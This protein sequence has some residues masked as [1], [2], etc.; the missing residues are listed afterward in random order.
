[1]YGVGTLLQ[2]LARN[3][4]AGLLPLNIPSK[5]PSFPLRGHMISYRSLSDS[6]DTWNAARMSTYVRELAWFGC[7][8]IEMVAPDGLVTPHFQVSQAEMLVILS[9][10]T[11][12]FDLL[13]SIWV[14]Q[15]ANASDPTWAQFVETLTYLDAVFIPAGDP[16]HFSS[17]ELFQFMEEKSRMIHLYHPHCQIW[18]STQGLTKTETASFYKLLRQQQWSWLSGLVY[19]P[20]TRDSYST[21]VAQ[22][23]SMPLPL[24]IRIY[25]DLGH[26]LKSMFPMA[27]VWDP[28]FA[29]VEAREMV[30]PRP[31]HMLAA[32]A[33]LLPN[34]VGFGAYS[35]G[36]IDDVNK[37]V[38]SCA[39]MESPAQCNLSDLLL[40]YARI[41][42]PLSAGK[43]A[44]RWQAWMRASEDIWYGDGE[45]TKK[46]V[47]ET[48][49]A[50]MQQQSEEVLPWLLSH[51]DPQPQDWR[52]VLLVMRS[53]VDALI[54][55]RREIAAQHEMLAMTLL[56]D[57]TLVELEKPGVLLE[58]LQHCRVLLEA[59]VTEWTPAMHV[60]NTT[61]YTLAHLSF[62]TCGYQ[63]S[64]ELY[65]A[66][67]VDRGAFLDTLLAPLNNQLYLLEVA[68]PAI[69]AEKSLSQQWAALQEL[70]HWK[71]YPSYRSH[72]HSTTTT[73]A[74]SAF[75]SP[76]PVR[77]LHDDLGRA[78]AQPHLI[79]GEGIE[80]DPLFLN[81]TIAEFVEPFWP[82]KIQNSDRGRD[83]DNDHAIGGDHTALPLAYPASWYDYAQS[84]YGRPLEV[85]YPALPAG[86]YEVV[87]VYNGDGMG[88]FEISCDANG[89]VVHP[90][91]PKPL[92]PKKETF[93]IPAAATEVD[94]DLRIMF[95]PSDSGNGGNG[96]GTQVAEL[97]L[98]P[99]SQSE[100]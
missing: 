72:A 37:V 33:Q 54:L 86:L 46:W 65:G 10:I 69:A 74:F 66:F 93:A 62:L 16:G 55:F 45:I 77:C 12:A 81:T 63:A 64:V 9:N 7:N 83:N 31:T 71:E 19:G 4:F 94:G 22:V 70:V 96:R 36:C 84:F 2:H 25:P 98:C 87:I 78:G 14:P 89:E 27:P 35:D 80:K 41:F 58:T 42:L 40:V 49:V 1:M 13:V 30:S 8:Q 59:D 24:P 61:I 26:Q 6:Y 34:S 32:A 79:T 18:L 57:L 82:I 95:S 50:T 68:L 51:T 21:F 11:H 76:S 15:P 92:Q 20:H 99:R 60:L 43:G 53:Q 97:W 17:Q 100:G 28:A 75:S 52:A 47:A 91:R 90:P 85:V 5:S 56:S 3:D 44:N 39:G 23:Q 73:P 67:N 88:S 29:L 48:I 38:W